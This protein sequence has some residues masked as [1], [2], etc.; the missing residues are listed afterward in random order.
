MLGGVVKLQPFGDTPSLRRRKGLIQRR[1]AVGIEVVQD[2]SY[3]RDV[4]IGL[5]HQPAHLMGK[6]L[7]GAPLGHRHMAPPRQGLAGQEQIAGPL[8]PVLIVLTLRP[9]LALQAGVR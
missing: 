2:H 6:V 3:H 8:P 7:G 9:S 4:G 1:L 5:V